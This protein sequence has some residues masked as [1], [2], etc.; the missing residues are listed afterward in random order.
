MQNIIEQ[1]NGEATKSTYNQV[2]VQPNQNKLTGLK[3]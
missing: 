1:A 2:D 3:E